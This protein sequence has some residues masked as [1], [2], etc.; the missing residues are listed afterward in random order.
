V[1]RP[2][3]IVFFTASLMGVPAASR[4]QEGTTVSVTV[5]PSF[6]NFAG[7]GGSFGAAAMQLSIRRDFTRSVGGELTAFTLTPTGAASAIP[8]CVQGSSCVTRTTPSLLFGLMPSI[9]TW[10]GGSS[11]R[12]SGGFGFAG[13]VGGEGLENTSSLAGLLG[14]DWVPRSRNRMVPTLALRIVQLSSPIAGARQLLLPGLGI[15]F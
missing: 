4:A 15:S 10:I 1:I 7:W 12:L 5:S 9:Y 3:F 11:L 6:V 2:T 8:G 13:A 14:M